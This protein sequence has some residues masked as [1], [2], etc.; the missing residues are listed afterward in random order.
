ML[1]EIFEGNKSAKYKSRGQDKGQ[2]EMFSQLIKKFS[3]NLE[4]MDFED[5]YETSSL[6]F[7]SL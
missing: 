3:N 2:K 4:L 7:E 6:T 5:I 1:T